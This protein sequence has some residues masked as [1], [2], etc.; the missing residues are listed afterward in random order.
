M[1]LWEDYAVSVF[2]VEERE[3]QIIALLKNVEIF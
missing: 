1:N 3:S 2:W